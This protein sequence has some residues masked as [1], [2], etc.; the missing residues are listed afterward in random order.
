MDAVLLDAILA[1]LHHLGIGILIVCLAMETVLVRGPLDA[2]LFYRL[3]RID[4]GAGFAAALILFAGIGRVMYG[5]KGVEF[6]TSNHVFWTKMALF[7]LAA[8]ASMPVS[9]NII[10]WRKAAVADANFQ[11]PS[12]KLRT[13][14][15]HIKIEW[16]LI[17][18]IPLAAVLM[19]RGFGLR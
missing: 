3:A 6:Y 16:A 7:A 12:G 13:V 17:L 2:A 11:P 5:L 8:G 14:R 1:Y 19:A 10:K 9:I 4:A 15:R 18:L